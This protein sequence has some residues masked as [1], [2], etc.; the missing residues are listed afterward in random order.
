MSN[1]RQY[2]RLFASN[3]KILFIAR[4]FFLGFLLC[5]PAYSSYAQI[6]PIHGMPPKPGPVP[7]PKECLNTPEQTQSQIDDG[8]GVIKACG[9]VSAFPRLHKTCC[10]K[11]SDR[12]R[13]GCGKILETAMNC[14]KLSLPSWMP[15]KE[16]I[17]GQVLSSYGVGDA[18]EYCWEKRLDVL[19]DAGCISA[20]T[21][22]L[23]AR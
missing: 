1:E 13:D 11:S 6:N 5:C 10:A 2:Q 15:R 8:M 16:Y 18:I 23:S 17:C 20:S 3:A 12:S 7:L 4:I 14:C 22:E 9:K 19:S 21:V